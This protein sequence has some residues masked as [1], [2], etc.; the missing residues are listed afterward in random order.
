MYDVGWEIFA[1][2]CFFVRPAALVYRPPLHRLLPAGVERC[3]SSHQQ[4]SWST[5]D[6]HLMWMCGVMLLWRLNSG[7]RLANCS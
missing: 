7:E 2:L 6:V 5:A 4:V 3:C 1:W